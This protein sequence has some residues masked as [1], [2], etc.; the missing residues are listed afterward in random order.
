MTLEGLCTY[1][2]WRTYWRGDLWAFRYWCH[3]AVGT[4]AMS[5]VS[6]APLLRVMAGT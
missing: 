2:V 6:E 3:E 1:D 5:K 4:S